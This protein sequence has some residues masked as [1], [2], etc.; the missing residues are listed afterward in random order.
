MPRP[1]RDR[2]PEG[3]PERGRGVCPTGRR[4]DDQGEKKILV[5]IQPSEAVAKLARALTGPGAGRLDLSE[6]QRQTIRKIL[7][8]YRQSMGH[9]SQRV[10]NAIRGLPEKDRRAKAKEFVTKAKQHAE[11]L[12]R[13]VAEKL[14]SVL[15]PEQRR[16]ASGDED[17]PRRGRKR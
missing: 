16:E 11:E 4:E 9:L 2:K 14:R 3:R 1:G 8:W 7:V 5:T 13:K 10:S 15:T 6:K 12:G 17:R